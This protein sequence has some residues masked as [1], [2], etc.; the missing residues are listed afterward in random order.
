MIKFKIFGVYIGV[1][2]GFLGL[3]SLML[4]I[5]KTGLMLITL[6]ATLFHELGHLL[7]MYWLGYGFEKIELKIGAVAICGKFNHSLKSELLIAL[8]GPAFNFLF[9]AVYL[10]VCYFSSAPVL[11]HALVMLIMGIFHMLPIM[12]L[13]GGTVL[14]NLISRRF[15]YKTVLTTVNIVS[16]VFVFGLIAFGIVVLLDTRQNPSLVF[17]GLYLLFGFFVGKNKKE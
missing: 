8:A 5:D 12:G 3:L 13:D 4:Y 7:M 2:V 14:E 1:S 10:A 11:Y 17:L 15:S 16:L 9:F 6:Q